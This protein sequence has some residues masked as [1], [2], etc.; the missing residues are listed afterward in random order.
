[1][2]QNPRQSPKKSKT[3][4]L[5]TVIRLINAGKTQ[6]ETAAVLKVNIRTIQRWLADPKVK[7]RL[8]SIQQEVKEIAKSD[9]VVL[10]VTDIRAQ[11]QEIR[12]YRDSQRSFAL[13]MGE[14]V[15]RA[16]NI[17]LK[18][19]EQL[20]E[21]PNEVTVRTIPQLMRAV[22]DAGEKVSN[23]WVRTTGLDDLLESIKDEPEVIS[24]RAAEN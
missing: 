9:P 16:T 18:A 8:S 2:S 17:L 23:A 5:E 22:T 1:M 13:K 11:V 19:V 3:E 15:E 4:Q 24:Q 20:E 21:N 6:A 12:D 14:V 10:S 7:A